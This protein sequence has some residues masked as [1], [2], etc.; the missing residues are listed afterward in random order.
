MNVF[1]AAYKFRFVTYV[2]L[3]S[4]A[5]HRC[6]PVS[7]PGVDMWQGGSG[8]PSMVG[9][10]LRVPRFLQPRNTTERQ[11]PRLRE[12]VYKF[13]ELSVLIVFKPLMLLF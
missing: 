1:S 13:Y 10:F 4:L 5:C 9:G 12:R 3:D 8:R 7:I 11:R 6:C 2:G